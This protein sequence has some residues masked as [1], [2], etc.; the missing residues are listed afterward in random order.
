MSEY[1]CSLCKASVGDLNG[2]EGEEPLRKHYREKHPQKKTKKNS[3][4][5]TIVVV[6]EPYAM[7]ME[8]VK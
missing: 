4:G 2:P 1:R 3:E 7:E 8:L 5:K 6:L